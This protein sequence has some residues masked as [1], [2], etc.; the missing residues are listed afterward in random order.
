MKKPS[1][2]EEEYFTRS[3]YERLKSIEAEQQKKLAEEERQKAQELH[4]MKCPKCGMNLIEIAYKKIWI[5]KCSGC[6]GVWLDAGELDTVSHMD[7]NGL[8]KLFDVL[9]K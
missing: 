8:N 5:D 9:R 2:A 7:R 1:T 4:Y 3:E 6:Q